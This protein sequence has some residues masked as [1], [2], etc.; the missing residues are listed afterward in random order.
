MN[1]MTTL[2]QSA[3]LV[4]VDGCF[5]KHADP[6]CFTNARG[7]VLGHEDSPRQ[8][9]SVRVRWGRAGVVKWHTVADLRSGFRRDDEVQDIPRSNTRKT[10]GSGTV[11]DTRSFAGREQVLVH[12]RDTGEYRWLPYENLRRIGTETPGSDSAERLRLKTLAYALDSWNKLTGA[13]DRFDVDPLPHQIG[14]VHRIMTSDQS[15]WLIADDVG[16]GK[17][18]EVGLLLA[19]KKRRRA[20]LRALIV[21][22]AGMVRQWQDEMKGK[23]N[24]DFRIYGSDFHANGPADWTT[25]NYDKVIVSI[26]RA[27]SDRHLSL[28]SDSGNW[29]VI[30]IDEAHHLSKIEGQAV[31]QRYRLAE[32]LRRLTDE[33]IFLTGT[34]HQGNHEQFVNVLRLIRPDLSRQFSHI[35]TNPSVVAEVVLRNRK[36]MVTDG[37]GNFLFRGQD[38]RRIDATFSDS[39]RAFDERL[40]NY[41]RDGYNAAAGGGNTGRAIGFVM[42]T[43]RK[44]ASSSIVAIERALQRRLVRLHGDEGI[45]ASSVG[46][47][48]DDNL[49][50]DAFQDGTDNLDN[51]DEISDIGAA[52]FFNDEQSAIADLLETAK[53]VKADDRKMQQFLTEIVDPL[54]EENERLLVFTEYRA[55]QD[56]LVAELERRYPQSGVVQINGSMDLTEKRRSI[57][58]FNDSAHFMVSTEAGGEGFNLHENCHILA[59]YDLPWNPARLVQRSGRLYRYGQQERVIVFNLLASD[60]FDSRALSKMLER[61]EQIGADMAAVSPEYREGL[62][63]EIIGEILERID[64]ASLLA[65]NRAL[66]ID[67]TDTDIEAAIDR[68][69]ESQSLQEQLFAQVAG[70]DPLATAALTG[71]G[72]AETQAFLEGILPFEGIHIRDR[73]YDGRV[74][75]LG[76]PAEL[77]GK[78]SEFGNRTVVRVTTERGPEVRRFGATPMDFASEFFADLIKLAKSQEFKGQRASLVGPEPGVLGIYQLRWQNDQGVSTEEHLMPVFQPTGGQSTII[79]PDFFADLLSRTLVEEMATDPTTSDELRHRLIDLEKRAHIELSKRCTALRHPNDVILLTA[80]A[81]YTA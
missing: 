70:Y 38:T 13:L 35:F 67:R 30:V 25:Y 50:E 22:P 9:V 6:D 81:I 57:D 42:T 1:A 59:N 45:S 43:Y 61:V 3:P 66:N 15:N 29:D 47:P 69:R 75:E 23:F 18:I 16:L 19:A 11:T 39:A 14:L 21:C 60:G 31:T 33:F 65:D 78:Y 63:D 48:F 56:Y 7:V 53:T 64:V 37:Q 4:P 54:Q 36:S 24:E 27:K 34:P 52:P 2:Q 40:Q 51:L 72:S 46:L 73:L 80:A 44:L 77:R 20:T 8:S 79:N 17:T 58:R 41:L 12:L 28:F 62:E 76:L 68:A 49:N 26:D 74:L 32:M 10:L 55:T 5:V 71:F